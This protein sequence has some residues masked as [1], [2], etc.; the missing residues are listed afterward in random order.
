MVYFGGKKRL[1]GP[2]ILMLIAYFIGDTDMTWL[3]YDRQQQQTKK[4]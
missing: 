4:M 2:E 3:L 1:D